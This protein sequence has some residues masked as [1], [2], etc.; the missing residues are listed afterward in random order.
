[1]EQ[2]TYWATLVGVATIWGFSDLRTG[3]WAD[4]VGRI[5]FVVLLALLIERMVKRLKRS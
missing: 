2:L 5:I 4:F 1:M 3:D